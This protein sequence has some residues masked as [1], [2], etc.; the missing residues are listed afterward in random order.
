[1]QCILIAKVL[2]RNNYVCTVQTVYVSLE[3]R[4][5]ISADVFL[6]CVNNL[7][8]REAAMYC[9]PALWRKPVGKG[10]RGGITVTHS[11]R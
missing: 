5:A 7:M 2:N 1:M 10:A 9:L 6:V 11:W 8:W 3:Y 4:T